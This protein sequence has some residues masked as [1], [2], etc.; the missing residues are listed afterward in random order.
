MATR[1]FATDII[2]RIRP[3]LKVSFKNSKNVTCL[4]LGILKAE[5]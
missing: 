2:D 5:I 3:Q 1:R 4:V